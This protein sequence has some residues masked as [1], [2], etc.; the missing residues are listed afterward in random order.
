MRIEVKLFARARELAGREKV[1]VE[2]GPN[3][4]NGGYTTIA[5][6]RDALIREI[7]GLASLAPSLL[8]A[9][10]NHYA[11]DSV[12]ISEHDDVACFPPVSGG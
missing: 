11:N 8:I 4:I 2:L 5:H 6:L 12:S 1:P 7:P 3:E 9:V 10:G